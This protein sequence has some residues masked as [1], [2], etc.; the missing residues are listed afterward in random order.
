MFINI[1]GQEQN[2]AISRRGLMH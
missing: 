1:Y 2:T